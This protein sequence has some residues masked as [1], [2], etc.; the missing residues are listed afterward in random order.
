VAS[1]A[2]RTFCANFWGLTRINFLRLP[3]AGL[4]RYRLTRC[5]MAIV[6]S[7]KQGVKVLKAHPIGLTFR[8]VMEG[9]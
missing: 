9:V 3:I 6:R 1:L 7:G 2:S 8:K 4:S 5:S